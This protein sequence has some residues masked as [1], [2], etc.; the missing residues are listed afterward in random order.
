MDAGIFK[1]TAVFFRVDSVED[2]PESGVIFL[3]NRIFCGKP[4]ILPGIKGVSETAAGEA[5]NGMVQIMPALQN[6]GTVKFM[7]Q[8][9]D[10]R[11][12]FRGKYEFRLSLSWYNDLSVSVDIPVRVTGDGNRFLPGAY[13]WLNPAH[14]D[15]AAENRAVHDRPDRSVRALPHLFQT[16]F[17]HPVRVRRN[18]GTL[19]GNA[20]T[21]CR[22]RC[23]YGNPVIC[24]VSFFQTEVIILCLQIHVRKNQ[25]FLD[26]LPENPCHLIAVHLD[27]RGCHRNLAQCK[28]PL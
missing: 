10:L 26:H 1:Q 18:R 19:D 14:D 22:L 23:V 7:N 9:P 27:E 20:E 17:F 6:A 28:S 25:F 8:L 5:F 13:I 21:Q 2:L 4:Q 11:P 24:F 16:V 12:V 3:G 15:R